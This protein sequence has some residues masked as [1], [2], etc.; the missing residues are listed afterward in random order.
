MRLKN[1]RFYGYDI[2]DRAISFA[3]AF[4]EKPTVAVH[5]ITIDALPEKPAAIVSCEVIEHI[6]PDQVSDYCKNIADSL[7]NEGQLY[8]TTPTTNVPTN[9]K[10]YQHFTKDLLTTYLEPY[11]IIEEIAYLNCVNTYSKFLARLLANR[12]FIS[13][14][15][16]V[17]RWVLNQYK[18]RCLHGKEKTGSRIYI[19]AIKKTWPLAN[20]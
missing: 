7:A 14:S 15:P 18:K 10:H 17:N 13:N 1:S 9:A 2:S 19:K 4:T 3:K 11:F 16:T 5:D 12:F 8:L 20:Q 6:K